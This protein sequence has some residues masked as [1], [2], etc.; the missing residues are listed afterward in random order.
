MGQEAGRLRDRE[1]LLA[2]LLE[3]DRVEVDLLA[4]LWGAET[5]RG[6]RSRG[7]GRGGLRRRCGRLCRRRRGRR[8]G[9]GLRGRRWWRRRGEGLSRRRWRGRRRGEGLWRGRR[10]RGGRLRRRRRRS[11]S[12]P[13]AALDLAD[14]GLL[15]FDGAAL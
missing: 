5:R 11:A 8:R 3:G 13:W 7:L 4:G 12:L 15:G 2:Q 1:V 9:E 6:D 14:H 10:R